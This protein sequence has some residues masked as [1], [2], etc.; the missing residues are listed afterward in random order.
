MV[1]PFKNN[2]EVNV[3]FVKKLVPNLFSD[4]L[5]Q[6]LYINI[7]YVRLNVKKNILISAIFGRNITEL[8]SDIFGRNIIEMISAIFGR[9]ITFFICNY[10]L[11]ISISKLTLQCRTMKNSLSFKN[12]ITKS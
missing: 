9:D 11:T 2:E 12:K 3:F 7:M 4:K 6:F 10:S 8:I 5:V 1:Q